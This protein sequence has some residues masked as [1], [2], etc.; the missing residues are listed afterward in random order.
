[1][2]PQPPSPTYVPGLVAATWPQAF[3]LYSWGAE[4][5]FGGSFGD[6]RSPSLCFRLK[7]T[8]PLFVFEWI[9]HINVVSMKCMKMMMNWYKTILKHV[10]INSIFIP[11][12][13]A[14]HSPPQVP[15]V[16][17]TGELD[18]FMKNCG[19]SKVVWSS[20][21]SNYSVLQLQNPTGPF[22]SKHFRI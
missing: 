15:K 22:H 14:S 9:K 4:S 16:K 8:I 17:G 5:G 1:M 21:Q 18:R 20:W 19:P 11:Y 3:H 12:P 7:Q 6:H 2:M 13:K 10:Q